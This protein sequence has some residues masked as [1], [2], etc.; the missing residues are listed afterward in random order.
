MKL[1]HG[2]KSRACGISR[3]TTRISSCMQQS[4]VHSGSVSLWITRQDKLDPDKARA[5]DCIL[6]N[7]S[8][9]Q[10][11]CIAFTYLSQ[12]Q[13]GR[14]YLMTNTS[15]FFEQSRTGGVSLRWTDTCNTW[16][17][18]SSTCNQSPNTDFSVLLN[19]ASVSPLQ[20]SSSYG[21]LRFL[22]LAPEKQGVH[23]ESR[24]IRKE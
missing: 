13:K 15:T 17:Q 21:G 3:R 12:L 18:R 19:Y 9:W 16:P 6:R 14:K 8:R 7:Q 4:V 1:L 11:F 24:S 23:A 2:I 20:A 5:P 22:D 10:A